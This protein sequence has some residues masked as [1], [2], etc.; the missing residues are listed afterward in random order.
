MK[1]M[2]YYEEKLTTVF[3]GRKSKQGANPMLRIKQTRHHR[4]PNRVLLKRRKSKRKERRKIEFLTETEKKNF[5]IGTSDLD[6]Y[7]ECRGRS[8]CKQQMEYRRKSTIKAKRAS[9]A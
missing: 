7:L 4:I 1:K 8:N 9:V 3:I 6:I 5:V 2:F